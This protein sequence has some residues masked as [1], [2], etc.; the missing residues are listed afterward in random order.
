M[1]TA[2]ICT[3]GDEIL[4]G[5]IV[6]TNS[7]L[8]AKEL[9]K[10][11]IKVNKM[12]SIQDDESEIVS[13]LEECSQISDILIV[14]GGLGPTKDDITKR[15][16]AHLCR[17]DKYR[18]DEIQ[19]SIIYDLCSR[20]GI[21]LSQLNKDQALVP[22]CCR[23]LPNR[24]GT[25]PGMVF[26]IPA[27]GGRKVLLFS[28]PGVPYEMEHLLPSVIETIK[29]EYVCEN[30]FH[31]T[32]LTYGI[33]ESLL[34]AKIESWE[35][36]LPKEVKL[37]YLPS[38]QSGVKLRISIYGGDFSRSSLIAEEEISKLRMLLGSALYGENEETLESVIGDYLLKKGKKISVAESCTS[39]KLS[40][41]L[42]SIPGSSAYFAG[43]VVAYENDI[44]RD[45]L[46][47]KEETLQKYGAVSCE[48]VKEMAEGIKSLMKTDYAIATSGIAGPS[49][50]TDTKPVGTICIA[51]SGPD[52]IETYTKVFNG[53]RVRNV[54]R[55]SAEA[56]NLLRLRLGI[57]LM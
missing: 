23:V 15:S 21:A 47:V 13:S 24:M 17:C 16:L 28:M 3:I 6:D 31:R 56:L 35:D 36:N 7:S 26:T 22:E 50:G 44:K 45:L 48:C 12:I 38:P 10:C 53:D 41:L 34:A 25:A 20:R 55:F 33:P 40:S 43:G 42:T 14:T 57:Q 8:I 39:G 49:G 37:A 32:L 19:A 18:Y 54:Q 9:N 2:S 1:L 11:G 5:Q 4:I 46:G 52:F 27:S 29:K 30:I 51:I